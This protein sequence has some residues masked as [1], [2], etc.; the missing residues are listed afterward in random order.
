MRVFIADPRSETRLAL[1]MYLRQE[2][3]M[4]ITG[5]AVEAQGLLA[6]VEATQPDLV[7][8]D[9]YLPGQPITEVIAE[10]KK[11]GQRPQIIVLSVRPEVESEAISAG[12]DAFVTKAKSP[13]RLLAT[14]RK[15]ERRTP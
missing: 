4:H 15:I 7:L 9:W 8:L 3:G 5:I 10:L 6:Q 11:L 13:D 12:A 2:P 14:L 1:M